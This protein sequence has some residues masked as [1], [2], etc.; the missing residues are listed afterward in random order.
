MMQNYVKLK[1]IAQIALQKHL[2]NALFIVT[3]YC[4]ISVYM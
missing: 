1:A 2:V 4:C 3:E